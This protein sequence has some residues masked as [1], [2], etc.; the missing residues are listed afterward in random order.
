VQNVEF[1]WDAHLLKLEYHEYRATYVSFSPDGKFLASAFRGHTIQVWNTATGTH[2]VT[3]KDHILRYVTYM[4]FSPNGSRL[5]T[6][7]V[8]GM[9]QMWNMTTWTHMHTIKS[10]DGDIKAFS[11]TP[12]SQ[13]LVSV[14]DANI[15]QCWSVDTGTRQ[16]TILSSPGVL[17]TCLSSDGQLVASASSGGVVRLWN[18][19]TGTTRH[20]LTTHIEDIQYMEISPMSRFLILSSQDDRLYFWNIETGAQ[21]YPLNRTLFRGSIFSSDLQL[22]A[23]VG[24]HGSVEVWNLTPGTRWN[25]L[26][27]RGLHLKPMSFS[28]DSQV[29]AYDSAEGAIKLLDKTTRSSQYIFEQHSSSVNILVCSPDAKVVAS[30]SGDGDIQLWDAATC[31]YQRTLAARYASFVTFSRDS[32][33]LRIIQD[34]GKAKVFNVETGGQ[35]PALSNGYRWHRAVFYSSDG[36]FVA[37]VALESSNTIKLHNARTCSYLNTLQG[38]SGTVRA[39]AFSPNNKLLASSGDDMTIRIWHTQTG[40]V[41]SVFESVP[42]WTR[43]LVFSPDSQAMAI[44]VK[45]GIVWWDLSSGIRRQILGMRRRPRLFAISSD[46]K[47]LAVT[48]DESRGLSP[49]I[50]I[51]DLTTRRFTQTLQGYERGSTKITFSPK[52]QFLVV[53]LQDG[54]VGLWSMSSFVCV[55]TLSGHVDKVTTIKF[56]TDEQILATGSLDKTVRVWETTTGML[57]RIV[58]YETGFIRGISF[59]HH[60]FVVSVSGDDRN[61]PSVLLNSDIWPEAIWNKGVILKNYTYPITATQETATLEAPLSHIVSF[62]VDRTWITRGCEK[63]IWLPRVYRPTNMASWTRIGSTLFI[64]CESGQVYKLQVS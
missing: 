39:I 21:E 14:T 29:L 44:L 20:I 58:Q 60:E 33:F 18:L 15:I 64:G 36:N 11:F 2:L 50:A 25:K 40:V 22:L 30:V 48:I 5:A 46:T 17:L 63:I 61:N 51:W 28:P 24:R 37:F 54:T 16:Q 47:L 31:L 26:I 4:I 49:K 13:F 9:V 27:T 7:S 57:V 35:E 34:S 55:R 53:A 19:P 38:H 56:S 23:A 59:S 1:D 8:D 42:S 10:V 62:S 12:D 3:F 52:N 43:T 6:K 32:K 41:Q 45:G